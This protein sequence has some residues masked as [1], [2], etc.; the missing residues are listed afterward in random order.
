MFWHLPAWSPHG[1]CS[2]VS[3]GP[4]TCPHACL[5]CLPALLNAALPHT[6]HPRCAA[7][8]LDAG[9]SFFHFLQG[10]FFDP[11]TLSMDEFL[12]QFWLRRGDPPTP[13]QNAGQWNNMASWFPHRSV[14]QIVGLLA[15]WVVDWPGR[16]GGAMRKPAGLGGPFVRCLPARLFAECMCQ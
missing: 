15:C 13:M 5:T 4:R 14:R 2:Q 12:E 9:P 8:P 7:D 6:A 3:G 1:H 10:W 11:G 16:Q